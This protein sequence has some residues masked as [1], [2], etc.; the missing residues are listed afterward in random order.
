MI[1]IL[2]VEDWL[3]IH[4]KELCEVF[5][6]DKKSKLNAK[7]VDK[8]LQDNEFIERLDEIYSIAQYWEN[9]NLGQ[10]GEALHRRITSQT[11]TLSC[12]LKRKILNKRKIKSFIDLI[13][14][15]LVKERKLAAALE[16]ITLKAPRSNLGDENGGKIKCVT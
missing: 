2:Y 7:T 8:L 15:I 10:L 16:Y 13:E 11:T 14:T 6:I 9:K 1:K 12:F 4:H 3:S 5:R